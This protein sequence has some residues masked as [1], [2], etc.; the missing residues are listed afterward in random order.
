MRKIY[1]LTQV[2]L[3]PDISVETDLKQYRLR[4]KILHIRYAVSIS[5]NKDLRTTIVLIATYANTKQKSKFNTCP[6]KISF[7][8]LSLYE[9]EKE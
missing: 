9:E 8:C 4:H 6:W 1:K 2:K 7:C 3:W 5:V